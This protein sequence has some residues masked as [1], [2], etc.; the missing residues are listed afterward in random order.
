MDSPS[1]SNQ[2]AQ[3]RPRPRNLAE[4]IEN[5]S[6]R[7]P[8]TVEDTDAFKTPLGRVGVVDITNRSGQILIFCV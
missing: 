6:N 8:N 2:N 5:E 4:A 7:N 1:R 3:N